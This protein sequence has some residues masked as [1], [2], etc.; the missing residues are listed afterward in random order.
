MARDPVED[1]SV[2]KSLRIL[3]LLAC[4]ESMRVTE[5]SR[6]LGVAASTAHR[7]LNIMR[8]HDF[9]EQDIDSPRYRLGPA[10]LKLGRPARSH[11]HLLP[12]S[13]PYLERLSADLNETVNLVVLDGPDALF[14]D[15]IQSRQAVRVATRTGARLPAYTTAGGKV[16]LACLPYQSLRA[17]Y[18]DQLRRVTKN[19]LPDLQALQQE[20]QKV[21]GHGYALN[22]G[23]HLAEVY[24]IGVP[25]EGADGRPVAAVTVAGPAT[26]WNRR[27]LRS[28]AP[29]VTGTAALIACALAGQGTA[30]GSADGSGP[31]A[32][33]HV[34]A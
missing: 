30:D 19:T 2:G 15:G 7:L 11:P 32:D 5:L 12:V 23:E 34:R 13:H 22:L 18:P 26:R 28:L 25:V 8:N 4:H 1:N 10:A 14:L 24:A 16:L 33:A 21:R 6:E 29:Q 20:L 17:L 31:A 9:V 3:Q 27:A